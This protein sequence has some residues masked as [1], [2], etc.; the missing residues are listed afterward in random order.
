MV[1]RVRSDACSSARVASLYQWRNFYQ[2]RAD[3]LGIGERTG[4]VS[5]FT[6]R[7][8]QSSKGA[9]KSFLQSFVPACIVRNS[10]D[11]AFRLVMA[12]AEQ[13]AAKMCLALD[14]LR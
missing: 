13:A 3:F 5:G 12:Q 2:Q 4:M 14:E 11:I 10:C 8:R 9:R 1:Q 7:S 6:I